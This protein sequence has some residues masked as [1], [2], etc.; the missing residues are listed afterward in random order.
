MHSRANITLPQFYRQWKKVL[1][2]TE[3]VGVSKRT[4]VELTATEGISIR[5][6]E[7][8]AGREDVQEVH[9]FVQ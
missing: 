9:R 3:A 6:A 2:I 8:G 7:S 1:A 5:L 4:G